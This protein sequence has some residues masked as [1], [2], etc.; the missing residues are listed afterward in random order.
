M[1][2]GLVERRCLVNL[3]GFRTV[4]QPAGSR[5]PCSESGASGRAGRPGRR[6]TGREEEGG[7]GR[8]LDKKGHTWDSGKSGNDDTPIRAFISVHSVRKVHLLELKNNVEAE[9]GRRSM[10]MGK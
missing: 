2:D 3:L 8:K 10:Q 5:R 7:S 1:P 6:R 4:R 9:S